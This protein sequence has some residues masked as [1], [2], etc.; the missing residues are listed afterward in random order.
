MDNPARARANP[1]L[2]NENYRRGPLPHGPHFWGST[3][4]FA[5][6][7]REDRKSVHP[8]FLLGGGWGVLLR[9][10]SQ[11]KRVRTRPAGF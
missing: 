8:R 7:P 1:L 2:P 5:M 6:R 4:L 11:V 3:Q 9:K 10:T